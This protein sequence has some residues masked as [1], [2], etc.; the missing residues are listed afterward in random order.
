LEDGG[1]HLGAVAM[2]NCIGAAMQLLPGARYM[3]TSS[4]VWDRT[5]KW[6]RWAGYWAGSVGY[7]GSASQV[8]FSLFFGYFLFF[9]FSIFSL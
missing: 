1:V 2:T 3:T 7:G 6:P 8:S 5:G 9:L 4:F